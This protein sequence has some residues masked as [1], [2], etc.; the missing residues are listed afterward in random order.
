MSPQY[1]MQNPLW[2]KLQE[3]DLDGGAQFSFSKRL[4][5]DNGWTHDFALRVCQEYKKFLYLACTADHPITPSDEVDQAWH[6]HLTYSRSYWDE[7]CAKVLER[8]FHHEPTRGGPAE[9]AKFENWYERTLDSY[10][11]AFETEPP[12]DIWPASAVRFGEAPHYRRVNVKRHFVVAK[13]QFSR[14]NWKVAP[15]LAL[16][17]VLAGCS[18]SGSLNPFNW[19]GGEFLTLFWSLCVVAVL[20]DYGLRYFLSGPRDENFPIQSFDPYTLA[21]LA[22]PKTLPTDVALCSLQHQGLI[23]TDA[24]G[25]ISTVPLSAPPSHPFER[26][27][28]NKI[29]SQ[30]RLS[31]VRGAMKS[32]F[33]SMDCQLEGAGLLIP[34]D[35]KWNL[36][37]GTLSLMLALLAFGGIKIIVGLQRD[38]PVGFLIL[39]CLLVLAVGL[40]AVGNNIPHRTGR[41]DHYLYKLRS[42]TVR[43]G[44]YDPT[45]TPTALVMTAALWG[46]SELEAYGFAD[47][48]RQPPHSNSGDSGSSDSGGDGGGSGCGGGCGGCGGGGD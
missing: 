15:A 12:R 1:L 2:E 28:W 19:Y 24:H 42:S 25:K 20:L 14:S 33:D 39:S 29:G 41:G 11:K 48:R 47:F 18:A 46:Y 7:L 40:Y 31:G 9:G 44:R 6:L 3:F 34:K 13:P 32:T 5:R 16:A 26:H 21:R 27:V 30:E 17:M 36:Q 35:R 23:Q 4:A 8:P 22:D 37:M 45:F 38:R 10:R 43:V